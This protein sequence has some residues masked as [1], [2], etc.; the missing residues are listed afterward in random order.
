VRIFLTGA[1]G[2][3]GRR[4]IQLLVSAGHEVTG[5]ARTPAKRDQI[6]RMGAAAVDVNLFD[7][8]SVR[9]ALEGHDTI[10][11]L[12]THMPSS[13]W[14]MFLPGAWKENDRLRREG[15]AT[16][17][18]AGIHCGVS[19]F[20][21]ESFAPIYADCGERWIDENTPLRPA[22][23]NRTVV[24]AE[25][26]VERFTGG[27]RAGIVLRFALF[28]GADGPFTRE[29]IDMVRRG[30]APYPG[31]PQAFIS[32]LSHDDAATAA[33]AALSIRAGVYNVTD[34]EPLRRREYFDA[35]AAALRT[36]QPIIPAKWVGLLTGSLGEMLARSQRISNRKLRVE[37]GWV[38]SYPSAREGWQAVVEELGE[39][40]LAA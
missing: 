28:Y 20:I 12:A 38:P 32:S 36:R 13:S 25:N 8:G 40:V 37:S 19:R 10:I 11:N 4:V 7:P 26:A 9:H 18:N 39:T 15:S 29:M 17:V 5:V 35:L 23:Y 27:G 34:N 31:S 33:V 21:Q 16:L 2:V 24:D 14:R 6:T 30:F 1:T 3:I 22:R